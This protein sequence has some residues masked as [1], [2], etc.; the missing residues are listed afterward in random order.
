MGALVASGAWGKWALI[1]IAEKSCL[2]RK[3]TPLGLGEAFWL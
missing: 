3:I 2:P 1:P